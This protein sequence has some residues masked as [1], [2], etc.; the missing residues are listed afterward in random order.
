MQL[1]NSYGM[2]DHCRV[3]GS[4]W[5]EVRRSFDAQKG[6]S[7]TCICGNCKSISSFVF[8]IGAP[9][10]G[11]PEKVKVTGVSNTAFAATTP[12]WSSGS[13]THEALQEIAER[14]GQ[15]GARPDAVMLPY[16]AFEGLRSILGNNSA[17]VT[18][19]NPYFGIKKE[20]ASGQFV[21]NEDKLAK[22]ENDYHFQ[23]IEEQERAFNEE[24]ERVQA[25]IERVL[26]KKVTLSR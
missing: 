13:V 11:D 23:Q 21:K 16:N 17:K 10:F 3:C 25:K 5:A 12:R 7:V 19:E 6:Q 24:K 8:P 22:N 18:Q 26:G 14:I 20:T 9:F 15:Q 1:N 2:A 4:K